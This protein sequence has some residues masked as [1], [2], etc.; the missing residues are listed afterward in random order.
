[1][2]G[3]V[4]NQREQ[5]HFCGRSEGRAPTRYHRAWAQAL[6]AGRWFTHDGRKEG[7]ELKVLAGRNGCDMQG[8][9]C[10]EVKDPTTDTG[11][12]GHEG[13]H[14]LRDLACDLLQRFLNTKNECQHH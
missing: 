5:V 10:A 1:M 8:V 14:L 7:L 2:A 13:G 12:W 11:G 4:I 3:L 9:D 6:S